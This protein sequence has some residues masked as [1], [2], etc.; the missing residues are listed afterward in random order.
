M[1]AFILLFLYA[2]SVWGQSLRSRHDVDK[3]KLALRNLESELN[4]D[5]NLMYTYADFTDT[6]AI[7]NSNTYSWESCAVSGTGQYGIAT[8]LDVAGKGLFL[9]SN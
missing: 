6:W 1:L 3:E 9:H 8:T 7:S 2:S 5:S 4:F